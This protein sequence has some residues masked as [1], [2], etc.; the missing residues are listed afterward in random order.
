LYLSTDTS[1]KL[2]TWLSHEIAGNEDALMS[3]YDFIDQYMQDHGFSLEITMV[4][5]CLKQ[6]DSFKDVSDYEHFRLKKSIANKISIFN[7]ILG[8]HEQSMAVA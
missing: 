2:N 6:I 8:V 4:M 7:D 3:A 1:V 5:S